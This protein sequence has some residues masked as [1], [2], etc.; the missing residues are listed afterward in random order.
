MESP[1]AVQGFLHSFYSVGA[2]LAPLI[3]TT[4]IT[5]YGLEWYTW[6][7]VMVSRNS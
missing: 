5:K 3:A 7:Y 2:L 6:Y 4:M 1:N